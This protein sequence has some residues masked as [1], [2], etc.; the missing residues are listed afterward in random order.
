MTGASTSMAPFAKLMVP[1]HMTDLGTGFRTYRYALARTHQG[2]PRRGEL[3]SL[4]AK[5]GLEVGPVDGKVGP[6]TR[7]PLASRLMV[8]PILPSLRLSE[9]IREAATELRSILPRMTQ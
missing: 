4:L 7:G 1:R 8:M 2:M 3:Q 9:L 6:R 5:R